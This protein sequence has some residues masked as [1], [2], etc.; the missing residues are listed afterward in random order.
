MLFRSKSR[1]PQAGYWSGIWFTN[2]SIN[3]TLNGVII[4]YAGSRTRPFRTGSSY[5]GAAVGA[6]IRVENT[7]IVLNNSIVEHNLFKGLWLIN[8]PNTVV[9][10]SIF[11]NHLKCDYLSQHNF[12]WRKNIAIYID[13]SELPISEIGPQIKNSIFQNNLTGIYMVNNSQPVVENNN[14]SDNLCKESGLI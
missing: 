11:Q 12:D 10:N 4:R 2:S 13:S 1:C 9:E 6:A 7:S 8:S 14:F 3:S 5:S